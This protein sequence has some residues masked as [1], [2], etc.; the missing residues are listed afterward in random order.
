MGFGMT[1][2]FLSKRLDMERICNL[3]ELASMR[4]CL[5]EDWC[6]EGLDVE[7]S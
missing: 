6:G 7:G 2:S 3:Q 1:R 5:A 4:V